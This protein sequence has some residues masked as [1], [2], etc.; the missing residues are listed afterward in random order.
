MTVESGDGYC[1]L[2]GQRL[3]LLGNCPSGCDAG[4]DLRLVEDGSDV[5]PVDPD[6]EYRWFGDPESEPIEQ[7][8]DPDAA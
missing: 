8:D 6:N 1:R 2:C 4:P 3:N 7:E 5:E